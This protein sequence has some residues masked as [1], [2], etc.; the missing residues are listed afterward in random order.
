MDIGSRGLAD[1]E[2]IAGTRRRLTAMREDL[3]G[4]LVSAGLTVLGG[5]DLFRLVEK[6][7]ARDLYHRLGK[8]GIVVR[9]FERHTR[10]LRFGLP[11]T[12]EALERLST[13]LAEASADV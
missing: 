5:T 3:D 1:T 11:P 9:S 13:A 6:P 2:W 4:V 7:K 10:W 12:P 8:T